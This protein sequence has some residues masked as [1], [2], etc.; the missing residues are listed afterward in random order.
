MPKIVPIFQGSVEKGVLKLDNAESFRKYLA[1]LHGDVRVSVRQRSRPRTNNENSYYWAV[2]VQMI[3]D[4]LGM[5]PD[6][7]HEVIKMKFLRQSAVVKVKDKA[8]QVEMTRSTAT[9]ST[10]EFEKLM[11]DVRAWAATDLDI[12]IPLPNEVEFGK[13]PEYE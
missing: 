4:E 5:G 11:T 8:V 7:V 2:V 6:K 10:V 9:L 1:T 3:A 13:Y 12:H